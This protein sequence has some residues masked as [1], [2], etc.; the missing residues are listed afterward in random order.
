[1]TYDATLLSERSLLD[2]VAK[3]GFTAEVVAAD[4]REPAKTAT[5]PTGEAPPFFTAALATAGEQGKPLVVIFS[6]AWCAPCQ[7]MK[8]ETFTDPGVVSRLERCVVVEVDADRHIGLVKKFGVAGLPDV[9]LLLPDG[10][11]HEQLLG[12]QSPETFSAALDDLL[13]RLNPQP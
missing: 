3:T 10:S 12:F 5:P 11:A 9:R 7:R 13:G 1:M 2:Q 6:A 4:A 8:K